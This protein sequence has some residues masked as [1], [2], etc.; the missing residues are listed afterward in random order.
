VLTDTDQNCVSRLQIP[1]QDS[2]T[3]QTYHK[4]RH[5]NWESTH[6]LSLNNASCPTSITMETTKP[7]TDYWERQCPF[8]RIQATALHS[9]VHGRT[10]HYLSKPP[11]IQNSTL[12]H[13]A[14]ELSRHFSRSSDASMFVTVED[15]IKN[16]L[17]EEISL[18]RFESYS[19]ELYLYLEYE[20]VTG[21]NGRY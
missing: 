19:F 3:L 16:S 12:Q 20:G 17:P 15:K 8:A 7:A 11:R 13:S 21:R 6:L 4:T 10:L 1:F 2:I 5:K 18:Q 9:V 14:H